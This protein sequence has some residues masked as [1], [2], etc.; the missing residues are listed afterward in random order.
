MFTRRSISTCNAS[1]RMSCA[2]T[3]A[4]RRTARKTQAP[5]R[6]GGADLLDPRTGEVLALVGGRSYNQSQYNRAIAAKRQPGSAFKPFVYLAAFEHAAAE[7]RNDLTPATVVLDEPTSWEFN[8]QTWTPS[9]YDGNYEG[10][11]HPA[12]RAG[13]FAKHSDHQGR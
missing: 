9:N 6:A 12:P 2:R 5:E 10:A 11:D 1:R 8:E 3:R 7:G 4:P 13:A